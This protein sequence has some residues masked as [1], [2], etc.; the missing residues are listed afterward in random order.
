M[1]AGEGGNDNVVNNYYK[2][3]PSTNPKV[4][5]LVLNPYKIDKEKGRLPYGKFYLTGNYVDGSP[6]VTARNWCGVVMNGG[7]SADTAQSKVTTPFDLGPL[8][9]QAAPAAYEAVLNGAGAIYPQCDTLDQRI[10]HPHRHHHRRAGP[11]PARHALPHLAKSLAGAEIN[12]RTPRYR[13]RRHAR[14]LGKSSS[15][16][17]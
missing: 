11:L 8:A 5:A 12:P 17:P 2:P 3:G 6:A 15:P 7:T 1:Y 14:R 9:L 16:E 4:Q 10:A 13:P